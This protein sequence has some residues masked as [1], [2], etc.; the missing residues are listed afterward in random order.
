V[1]TPTIVPTFVPIGAAPLAAAANSTPQPTPANATIAPF[2]AT[3]T[4]TPT[5]QQPP[6]VVTVPTAAPPGINP[7]NLTTVLEVGLACLVIAVLLA[8][9]IIFLIVRDQK[10][11]RK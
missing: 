9:L 3:L 2:I 4:T 5:G 8:G 10:R 6:V 7:G 11:N 1:P